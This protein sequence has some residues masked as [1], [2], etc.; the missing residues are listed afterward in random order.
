MEV[1]GLLILLTV[2]DFSKS[3]MWNKHPDNPL[4]QDVSQKADIFDQAVAK[5][6]VPPLASATA[7]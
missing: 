5:F 4:V 2:T 6:A 7:A 1:C 3:Q